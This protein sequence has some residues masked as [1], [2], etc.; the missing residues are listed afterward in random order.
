MLDSIQ[1]RSDDI[2]FLSGTSSNENHSDLNVNHERE[3]SG[4]PVAEV[5]RRWRKA[6]K[7]FIDMYLPS[8]DDPP[9]S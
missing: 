8:L 6:R 9:A 4:I 2:A 1:P 7:T 3:L 5:F